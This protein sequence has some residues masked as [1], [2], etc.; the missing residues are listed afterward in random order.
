MG[1]NYIKTCLFK[2]VG[3][4]TTP[5]KQIN[6]IKVSHTKYILY[7]NNDKIITSE[8]F[9]LYLFDKNLLLLL[10]YLYEEN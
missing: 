4:P 8:D 5:R 7:S 6:N 2:A 10:T 1:Q 3:K 9:G